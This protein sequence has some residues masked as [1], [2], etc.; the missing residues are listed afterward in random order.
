VSSAPRILD[1]ATAEYFDRHLPEYGV[2]RLE[3]AADFIRRHAS[4]GSSLVDLGCGAGNTLA[5][6]KET[7]GITDVGGVD[8]SKRLLE[9]AHDELGCTTYHGSI[10]DRDFVLGLGRRF[11][12]AVLAAVLHHLIG[13]TRKESRTLARRALANSADLL[14]PGGHLVVH[15]PTFSPSLAMDAVFYVK[16][17]VSGVAP[18]R[19]AIGGSWNN[20]GAP[21]VSYYTNDQLLE[22]VRGTPGL[23]VVATTVKPDPLNPFVDAVLS[24]TA[25]TLAARRTG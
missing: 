10:F 25:T 13:R 1:R 21:V 19:V 22:M 9:R 3:P 23:E 7:T 6:L 18:R 5:Y 8:V 17:V 4:P 11:D 20:I 16:K 12:F 15:E 24:K 14:E 2:E